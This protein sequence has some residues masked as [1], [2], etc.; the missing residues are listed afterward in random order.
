MQ[1]PENENPIIDICMS[2]HDTDEELKI[3]I[4]ITLHKNKAHIIH[5][6][7][8][9]LSK[10]V[11]ILSPLVGWLF[12]STFYPR[13]AIFAEKQPHNGTDYEV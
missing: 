3:P 1:I 6:V 11:R 13:L 10:N 2:F 7:I 5:R 8:Q 12:T 9:I 4:K